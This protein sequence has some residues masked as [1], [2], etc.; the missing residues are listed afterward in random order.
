[1]ISNSTVVGVVG[2]GAMG[3]GIAQVA[4]QAGHTVLLHDRSAQAVTNAID[5]ITERLRRSSKKGRFD[6]TT[7]E[8][9]I[10]RLK[11]AGSLDNLRDCGLIIEAIIEDE[12]TKCDLFRSLEEICRN[13]VIL[14]TNTSSLLIESIANI[15]ARPERLAGMH[16][17]NPAPIMPLVEIV[18]GLATA[19]EVSEALFATASSWKKT[20]VHVTSSPGFIVNRVARPFY[21]VA[22]SLL[23]EGNADPATYDAVIRQSGLFRMGPFELIDLIGMDV[24]FAVSQS[25]FAAFSGA[26]RY[27]PS[28]TQRTY[29][30]AN[31]L[32]KK[33]GRGFFDYTDGASLPQVRTEA[34]VPSGNAVAPPSSVFSSHTQAQEGVVLPSG[35]LLAMTDGRTATE[36][37]ANLNRAIIL[38]DLTLDFNQA[39]RIAITTS[40]N[41]PD[42]FLAE[43]IGLFQ[44][45]GKD[46][47]IVADTPGLIVMRTVTRLANEAAIVVEQGVAN[48]PSVDTAMMNGV[49]YPLGPMAWARQ[50]GWVVVAD[51]LDNIE[52]FY[53]DG[54]HCVA[55][56]IRRAAWEERSKVI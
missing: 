39:E 35:G 40:R 50:L 5:D 23:D 30:N 51:V 54:S 31:Y 33:T 12:T 24:N 36:R 37:V 49:N 20:P 52:N 46:V 9:M 18:S 15:L 22:L 32:G 21:G 34:A 11:P 6:A 17:F 47:S 42:N 55:P 2:S 4:V 28:H 38:F 29:V 25:I 7:C 13:D 48:E 56:F 1:M 43:V 19:P 8:G 45:L 26:P 41:C 53:R 10:K 27:R 44:S 16:F 3:A 14:A